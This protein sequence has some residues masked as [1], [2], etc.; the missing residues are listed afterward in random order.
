MRRLFSLL[1]LGGGTKPLFY[2][3]KDYLPIREKKEG[4]LFP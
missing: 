2:F 1:K 4:T 3:L